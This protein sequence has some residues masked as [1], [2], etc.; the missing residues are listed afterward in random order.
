[1]NSSLIFLSRS[2]QPVIIF[3]PCKSSDEDGMRFMDC[4]V[5]V[6]FDIFSAEDDFVFEPHDFLWLKEGLSRFLNGN[7]IPF[8]WIVS[9]ER[10]KMFFRLE[11]TG[12]IEIQVEIS[13]IYH[14]GKL[15]FTFYQDLSF[16]PGL[17]ENIDMLLEGN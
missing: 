9:E 7:K 4:R 15:E 13:N 11:D 2:G 8:Q 17:L 12:R 3:S 14:T 5:K 1:M 6:H 16:V 10:L